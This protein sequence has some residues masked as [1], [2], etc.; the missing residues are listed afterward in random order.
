MVWRPCHSSGFHRLS[1][2]AA[3]V[4]AQVRSYKICSGLSGTG[5]GFLRALQFSLP[6]IPPTA[7]HSSSSIIRGRYNRPNSGRRA[8]QTRSHPTPRTPPPQIK[9]L[10]VV[11]S[12]YVLQ[13]QLSNNSICNPRVLYI[14]PSLFPQFD[15]REKSIK[16]LIT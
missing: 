16:L 1:I 11:L 9:V 6:I 8:K 7:P 10:K 3:R 2:A 15:R 14:G 5:A 12:F 4:R 13:L